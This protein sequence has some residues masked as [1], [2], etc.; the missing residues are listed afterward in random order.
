MF[1]FV[2]EFVDTVFSFC[3]IPWVWVPL[4]VLTWVGTVYLFAKNSSPY[5]RE[6]HIAVGAVLGVIFGFIAPGVVAF[7][8]IILAFVAVIMAIVLAGAGVAKLLGVDE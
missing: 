6:F 8:P 5:E 4:G 3:S 7:S 1:A 2:R